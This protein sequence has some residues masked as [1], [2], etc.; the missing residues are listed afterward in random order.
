V[1]RDCFFGWHILSVAFQKIIFAVVRLR[2]E[3]MWWRR[4]LLTFQQNVRILIL[5]SCKYL[6]GCLSLTAFTALWQI[7][8]SLP[9]ASCNTDLDSFALSRTLPAKAAH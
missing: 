9:T 7:N 5:F 2:A 8:L 1:I 6:S 3:V 4:F